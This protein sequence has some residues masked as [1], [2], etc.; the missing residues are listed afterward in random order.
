[1]DNCHNTWIGWIVEITVHPFLTLAPSGTFQP[2]WILFSKPETRIVR[3][4]RDEGNAW[5]DT[6]VPARE[7]PR[8]G[9][10]M[11]R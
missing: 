4:D 2:Y 3:S 11:W 9:D 7:I 8:N 1:M 5:H 10:I 6:E